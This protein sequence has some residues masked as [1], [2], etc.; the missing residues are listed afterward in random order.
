MRKTLGDAELKVMNVIWRNGDVPA[1]K[2]AQEITDT[3]GWNMNTTYTLI[4]RCIKKGYL[5]RTEPNFIC[6]ALVAK[7]QVQEQAAKELIE[8][9]FDGSAGLLF[10]ALVNQNNLSPQDIQRLKEQI[11]QAENEAKL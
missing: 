11:E 6:R 10:A 1:R 8:K 2:V 7:E 5:E 4:K 9:I 3:Y